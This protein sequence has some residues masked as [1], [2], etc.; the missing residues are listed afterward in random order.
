MKQILLTLILPF[1]L[2]VPSMAQKV[3]DIVPYKFHTM[4]KTEIQQQAF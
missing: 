2:S 1:L 4:T 3:S